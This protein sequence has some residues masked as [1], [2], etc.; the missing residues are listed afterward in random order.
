MVTETD[1]A[2]WMID[3]IRA[4]DVGYQEHLVADIETR[5]GPEWVYQ[6]ESG[7]PAISKTVLSAFKKLHGGSIEW[8]KGEKRWVV[9]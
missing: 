6:N 4:E 2:Q 3:Q 7:N 8:E 9:V 5:F 1:V